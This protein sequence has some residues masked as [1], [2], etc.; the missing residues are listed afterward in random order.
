[1]RL[2][3]ADDFPPDNRY[4]YVSNNPLPDYIAVW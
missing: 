4:S 2:E 1:M 3:F